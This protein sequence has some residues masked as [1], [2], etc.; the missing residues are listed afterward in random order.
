MKTTKKKYLRYAII[1]LAVLGIVWFLLPAFI[2][3]INIGNLTGGVICLLA[4]LAVWQWSRLRKC[5]G[6]WCQ[7]R[8]G[9]ILL[10]AASVILAAVILLAGTCTGL[11]IAANTVPTES[12]ATAVVLGCRVYGEQPSLTL[13]SR[14][15]AAYEYLTANPEA[16][17][18]LSGGQG[19]DEGISEAECI[20]RCLVDMGIDPARLHKEERSTSTR[21]N[22]QFS[23]DII[24]ANNLNS[25]IV[26]VTNEFHQYRAGRIAAGLQAEYSPCAAHTAWWLFPT[27]YM[28]ELYGIIYQHIG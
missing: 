22:L 1:L 8:G 10:A 25:H 6:Q 27:Y 5:L 24:K 17:A 3:M 23:L 13:R 14:I 21:E 18:V 7:S 9:K 11:M 20:Y 28:R 15:D 26:I 4:G 12:N 16:Q 19:A 2:G